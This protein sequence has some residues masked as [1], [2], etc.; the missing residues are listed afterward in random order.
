VPEANATKEESVLAIL[1][2]ACERFSRRTALIY[3]GQ[4]MTYAMLKEYV[5]RF[6]TALAELGVK[7]NDKVIIYL[8]NSPQFVIAFYGLMTMGAVPVP[9][10]PIYTP[11]EVRYMSVDCGADTIVC[12]DTNFGYAKEAMAKGPLK[13]M[14]HTNLIDLLP[15]WK[16]LIGFGFAKVPHGRIEKGRDVYRFTD[17]LKLPPDPPSV[18]MKL[19]DEICRIL[20]T[21]G[22]TGLPKG[23]PST[24]AHLYYGAKEMVDIVRDTHIAEG[25]SRIVLILPLYHALCQ[26]VFSGFVLALGNT[27]ILMPR[28]EVDAI[29]EAIQRSKADLFLGVPALYRMI[30][31]ND[32]LDQYDLS[33]LKYCWSGGDVLPVELF[34]QWKRKFSIPL[35]QLYGSTEAELHSSTPMAREPKPRSLGVCSV[36]TGKKYKLVDADTLETIPEGTPGELLVSA[37]FFLNYYLNK[38]DETAGSFV[39]LNGD[40]Y[41]RTKDVLMMKEGELYFLDRSADVIKHKGY[42][43]SASEIEAILQDHPNVIGT[44]VVG[45]PDAIVGERIKAFVVLKEGTRGIS[46]QDLMKWCRERLAPYK[47]P[48]YIEF[49]DMLPKSKVGKLL[50]REM[51][52]EERRKIR[53]ESR[54]QPHGQEF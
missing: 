31:E 36:S 23:V 12:H 48:Q 10:S 7:K 20:Y 1:S 54:V 40:T 47:V 34:N 19:R 50:R 8:A 51:R 2:E 28:P 16:R 26:A 49:R 22:T 42:R 25:R 30:V 27:A 18:R 39:T 13:R 15:W 24:Y 3:L 53:E 14:I 41:Y 46:A 43:V 33:S 21:G 37:P 38:P 9:I 35:H 44:C 29:L 5:D 6:A 32:R 45:V 4:P 11:R 52:E 17:L